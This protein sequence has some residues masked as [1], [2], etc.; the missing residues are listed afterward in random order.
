MQKVCDQKQRTQM[1]SQSMSM[2]Q[3]WDEKCTLGFWTPRPD[4][5]AQSRATSTMSLQHQ[6]KCSSLEKLNHCAIYSSSLP[7]FINLCNHSLNFSFNHSFNSTIIWFCARVTKRM[8]HN[9]CLNESKFRREIDP[10]I[11]NYGTVYVQVLWQMDAWGPMDGPRGNTNMVF[12]KLRKSSQK[13]DTI[14]E[15]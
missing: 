10:S 2:L 9:S 3:T 7:S 1:L 4:I 13:H 8:S 5:L 15:Q 6:C 11:G 12:R 14:G